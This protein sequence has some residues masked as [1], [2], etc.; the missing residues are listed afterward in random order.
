MQY[1]TFGMIK[2]KYIYLFFFTKKNRKD[3]QEMN[4]FNYL[5]DLGEWDGRDGKRRVYLNVTFY[6]VLDF[7]AH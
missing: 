4:E 1:A 3:K 5:L 6:T 7:E 2:V